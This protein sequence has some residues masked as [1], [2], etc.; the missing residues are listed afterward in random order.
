VDFNNSTATKNGKREGIT[1][2]AHKVSPILAAFKLVLENTTKKNRKTRKNN[3][4][5]F[6][7][8][9]INIFIFIKYSMTSNYMINIVLIF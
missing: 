6:L 7:L 9:F 5:R 4:I 3:D 1:L 8:I 2:V